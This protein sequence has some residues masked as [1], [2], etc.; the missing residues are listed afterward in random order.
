MRISY[1]NEDKFTS[2]LIVHADKGEITSW[3]NDLR[4]NEVAPL[5][6]SPQKAS[7]N[8][9]NL[10]KIATAFVKD[11]IFRI[12]ITEHINNYGVINIEQRRLPNDVFKFTITLKRYPEVDLKDWKSIL[13][14]DKYK[15]IKA[16]NTK[17][18]LLEQALSEIV[19]KAIF[20]EIP[21]DLILY[22]YISI[23]EEIEFNVKEKEAIIGSTRVRNGTDFK[24]II[25]NNAT[26]RIKTAI[27]LRKL[28]TEYNISVSEEE[29]QTAIRGS[30]TITGLHQRNP[31]FIEWV[32]KC[33]LIDKVMS[34]L[35]S[36]VSDYAK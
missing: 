1:Y 25:R 3:P 6:R 27:A 22:E 17:T 30:D 29:T 15:S 2:L 4:K 20:Q 33:V 13:L 16:I 11:N 32:M 28:I 24:A 7:N 21:G 35:F 19:Q 23:I 34:K 10:D 31:N 8:Y 26:E 36:E 9:D 12:L 5:N 14:Q 18:E